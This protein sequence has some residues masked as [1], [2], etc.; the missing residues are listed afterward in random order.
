[1]KAN[2]RLPKEQ[3][4]ARNWFVLALR[5]INEPDCADAEEALVIADIAL[6]ELPPDAQLSYGEQHEP[7]ASERRR[8]RAVEERARAANR[9]RGRALLLCLDQATAPLRQEA[10]LAIEAFELSLPKPTNSPP[11]PPP[12]AV[13]E[14]G[15]LMQAIRAAFTKKQQELKFQTKTNNKE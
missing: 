13:P 11:A 7:Q 3:I 12:A 2:D 1:M 6:A 10:Q 4:R 5:A 9:E 15:E 8:P 14:T